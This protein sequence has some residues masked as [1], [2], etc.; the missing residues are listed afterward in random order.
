MMKRVLVITPVKDSWETTLQTIEGLYTSTLPFAYIVYNDFSKKD[1]RQK[2]IEASEQYGFTLVHLDEITQ[3]P[4]PNYKLILQMAQK[5]AMRLRMPL[6]IVESDVV[7]APTTLKEL[8]AMGNRLPNAG[9]VGSVTVDESGRFNFPYATV[10]ST[11]KGI[12]ETRKSLSFCAT[13]ITLSFLERYN[14]GELSAN[15]D[16]FDIHISRQSRRLGFKNYLSKRTPV[17]HQPH[18]SRPWKQLKYTHPLQYYW[19]K[20]IRKRDRI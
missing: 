2:L 9:M 17:L 3:N 14:F 8:V 16:W 7:V 18:S 19:Y 5:E 20:I 12:G 10:K 4:S 6:L 1:T 15:K 13:L 11:G